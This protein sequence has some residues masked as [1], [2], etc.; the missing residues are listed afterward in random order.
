MRDFLT[1]GS[2]GYGELPRA[3]GENW[4]AWMRRQ[5]SLADTYTGPGLKTGSAALTQYLKPSS[6]VSSRPATAGRMPSGGGGG[7]GI[8]YKPP[9]TVEFY[10]GKLPELQKLEIPWQEL[11]KRVQETN[12][13][14]IAEYQKAAPGEE[15]T[16]RSLSM[17]NA[18]MAAGK[19]PLSFLQ[20][21]QRAS[22]QAGYGTGLGVGGRAGGIQRMRGERDIL[23][24]SLNLQQRA[25]QMAAAI[26]Q[27]MQG[28]YAA[29]YQIS[30]TEIFGT[31]ANQASINQQ[32]ANQQLLM[33]WMNQPRPGMYDVSKGMYVGAQPGTYSATPTNL[34][35]VGS[36]FAGSPYNPFV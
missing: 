8:A 5:Q 17:A 11:G 4:N 6:D 13:P 12:A 31:A 7:G 16:L 33:N 23:L 22:A 26:P 36:Y 32:L 1:K 2:L 14:T 30:P 24:T 27:I 28:R 3:P 35:G 29:Q 34:P 25:A 15:A 19:I 9:T 18:D 20:A 10:M 21:S